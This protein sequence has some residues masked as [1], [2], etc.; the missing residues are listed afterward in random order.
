MYRIDDALIFLFDL[1]KN[2]GGGGGDSIAAQT[3]LLLVDR[4]FQRVADQS[5]VRR[6]EIEA[7]NS[8]PAKFIRANLGG[9]SSHQRVVLTLREH[10]FFLQP[11]K[12]FLGFFHICTPFYAIFLQY[13]VCHGITILEISERKLKPFQK[14]SKPATSQQKISFV[15]KLPELYNNKQQE[16]ACALT[17][18]VSCICEQNYKPGSVFDSH[19]SRRIVADTLKPPRERPGQPLGK[20]PMLP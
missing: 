11:L 12:C 20:T 5:K 7:E 6:I 16:T 1:Q 3:Q 10:I 18:A 19:L 4:P 8:A 2:R 14:N 17:R 15:E 9:D 13:A